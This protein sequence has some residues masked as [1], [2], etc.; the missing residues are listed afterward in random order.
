MGES[1]VKLFNEMYLKEVPHF[2]TFDNFSETKFHLLCRELETY[3]TKHYGFTDE[4]IASVV[5]FLHR[6]NVDIF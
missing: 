2:L 6:R 3:K 5:E 1:S 4:Q